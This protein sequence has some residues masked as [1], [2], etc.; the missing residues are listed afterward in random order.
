MLA[1]IDY[2]FFF[3][4]RRVP[5]IGDHPELIHHQCPLTSVLVNLGLHDPVVRDV[6]P[7]SSFSA[8]IGSSMSKIRTLDG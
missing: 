1:V 2:L 4:W 8:A 6:F 7:Q 5:Q 3:F